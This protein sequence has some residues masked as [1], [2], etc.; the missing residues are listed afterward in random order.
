MLVPLN[1]TCS[2]TI[3]W[4]DW[5]ADNSLARPGKKKLIYL[6]EWREFPSA[7]C[8]AELNLDDSSRPDVAEVAGVLISP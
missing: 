8:L 5:G 6:S 2:A 3:F 7:P 4:K 1:A